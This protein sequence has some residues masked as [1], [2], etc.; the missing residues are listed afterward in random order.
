MGFPGVGYQNLEPDQ[1]TLLTSPDGGAL[2]RVIAGSVDDVKGP[3]ST[4]TPI[5]FLHVSIAPDAKV[6]L[7]WPRRFNALVYVLSGQGIL[8]AEQAP[9]GSGQLG[10]LVDG[11]FIE[12]TNSVS[13]ASE[14]LEILV[15][16]GEPI[17]EPV[18][19]QG[20]FV[21]NTRAELEQAFDDFHRGKMGTIPPSYT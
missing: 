8:G 21:M 9:I 3:G 18:A 17:K 5:N 7:D 19:W 15:L 2:I 14:S 11:D 16:G 1:V 12:V 13:Q 4:T 20:P 10:V 6:Q